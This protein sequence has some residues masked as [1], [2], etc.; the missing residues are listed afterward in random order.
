MRT[1]TRSSYLES[2][3]KAIAYIENNTTSDIQLKDIAI[4]ANLSQYH[5]HRIFKSLTGDTTKDFLTRLRLEKAA[6]KLKHSQDSIGQIS[7]DCGYQNHET[8]TRAFKDYFGLA[9]SDYS[10]SIDEFRKKKQDEYNKANI[11]LKALNVDSKGMQK[12]R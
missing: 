8:I 9:P 3:N 1:D 5:F 6:L 2:I 10:S 4:H 12:D 7:F 11:D